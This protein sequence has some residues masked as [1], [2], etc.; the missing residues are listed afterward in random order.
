M[1]VRCRARLEMPGISR[2]GGLR[3]AF[4]A[5]GRRRR[6]GFRQRATLA[7]E[8]RMDRRRSVRVQAAESPRLALRV[9][10]LEVVQQLLVGQVPKPR[11]VVRHPI[12]V[13]GDEKIPLL[14]TVHPLMH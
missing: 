6:K 14:I 11:A 13:A 7:Q 4:R 8:R 12:G 2:R 10:G 5:A 3:T 9:G 1:A